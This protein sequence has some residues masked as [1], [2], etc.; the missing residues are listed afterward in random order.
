MCAC[1]G[2]HKPLG[3]NATCED[4]C[5]GTRSSPGGGGPSVDYAA[6]EA[7][8]RQAEA[9]AAER[10]RQ[11]EADR[12]ERERQAEIKRQ[13]DAEFIRNRDAAA[14]SL[15]GS[16]GAAMSQ[17]KGLSGAD[18]GGLKGSGFDTGSS[19]LR[20]LRGSDHI[21]RKDDSKPA[22]HTDTSVVDAR[23]VPSGLPKS[24]DDAIPRT[25]SGD[26]V[27]KGFQAIQAGNW[28][29][30]L[31]WFQEARKKEPD[32]PGIARLVDLA[33]FTL[34]Y[35]KP[36]LTAAVKKNSAAAQPAP[37]KLDDPVV[38]PGDN[39]VARAAA[40]QM[41]ARARADAAFKQY[42]EKHGDRDIPGRASAVSRAYRGEEYSDEELKAQLRKAL[43]EYRENYRKLYPNGPP[44]GVGGSA[45][46][47]EIILGGKG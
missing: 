36:A 5:Y 16:T 6:I 39:S 41:A 35:R 30:A 42:V 23:K 15:K 20:E 29:A 38:Q 40:S 13:K 12:I 9:A 37:A 10:Q 45:A 18:N 32:N 2:R 24:L 47:E 3:N 19:G 4:A 7:Q 27:R 44:A 14:N 34:E 28:K 1:P 17:L 25:A 26:R 11:A 43:Q 22:P 33:K 8:R 21:I 31:A 46:H